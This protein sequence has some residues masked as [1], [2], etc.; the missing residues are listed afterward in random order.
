MEKPKEDF[1]F[2]SSYFILISWVQSFNAVLQF[3][4]IFCKSSEIIPTS[5]FIREG[6]IWPGLWPEPE[7]SPVLQMDKNNDAG[8][9][10]GEP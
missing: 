3:D 1:V 2:L 7:T 5:V 10:I 9:I 6:R 8:I 4:W